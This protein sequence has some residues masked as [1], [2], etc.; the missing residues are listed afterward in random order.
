MTKILFEDDYFIAA[1]KPSGLL[2]HPSNEC[3][4][5]KESLLFEIRDLTNTYVYPV[6]RLDRGVSGINLFSKS[7]EGVTMMQ[8]VWP[9]SLK[10]YVGL[11]NGH[12]IE[13]GKHE[14]D[15]NNEKKIPQ[16]AVT[17]FKVL[18]RF[19]DSTLLEI[20]IETGRRH[21]IRR[22]FSRRMQALLGDRKYGKKKWND[23]Y[24]D[25]FELKRIFLHST[26]LKFNHPYSNTN[27]VIDDNLADD[28]QF[29]LNMI[30]IANES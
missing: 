6:N 11:V 3:R 24:L 25:S 23:N 15:L 13:D 26:K 9:N 14:F 2:T 7:K 20:A 16:K 21:Q 28:L 5:I 4:Q 12:I 1:S 10:Q 29:S 8:T 17:N 27:I 19:S 18:E 22:H 30:R